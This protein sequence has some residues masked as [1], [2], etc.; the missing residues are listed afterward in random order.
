[1]R[2]PPYTVDKRKPIPKRKGGGNT[3][4]YPFRE[5]AVGDSFFAPHCPTSKLIAAACYYGPK[6][7][8]ARTVTERGIPGARIW[9][10]A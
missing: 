9:R 6:R 3:S 2:Q 4:K 1:M 8:S 5:M 10:I 7:F